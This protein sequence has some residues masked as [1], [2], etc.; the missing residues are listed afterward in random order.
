MGEYLVI[1]ST[2]KT[3]GRYKTVK[4]AK[5]VLSVV[6]KTMDKNTVGMVCENKPPFRILYKK[7]ER[8]K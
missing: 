5:Q 1:L 6:M 3:V 8:E 4:K 7:I 2:G